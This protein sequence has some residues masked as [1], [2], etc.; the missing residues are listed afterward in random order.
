MAAP[1]SA[2]LSNIVTGLDATPIIRPSVGQ[3]SSVLQRYLGTITPAA[4]QAITVLDRMVRVPS[5]AIVEN[6]KVCFDAVSTTTFTGNIGVWYSDDPRDGTGILNAGNLT[7]ISSTFFAS[8]VAMG[9]LVVPTDETF[10]ASAAAATDGNYLPSNSFL[11]LWQAIAN[12][13]SAQ[14]SPTG[15]FTSTT[16]SL[17]FNT[18]S[19]NGSVF[20]I[21]KDPGGY[22]DIGVQLTTVGIGAAFKF[23]MFVDIAA[24]GV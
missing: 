3:V 22:F 9:A 20:V 13:L 18:P 11:P 5:N 24:P 14:N 10:A 6:V 2:V 21:S 12:S 23:N 16:Q 8:A 1:T 15:P 17:Q 4:T 7:A 19:A